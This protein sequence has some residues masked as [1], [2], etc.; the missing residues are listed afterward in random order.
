MNEQPWRFIVGVKNQGDTYDKIYDTLM[1]GNKS[2]AKHAPVLILAIAVNFYERNG[3]PNKH[4]EYD[5]GQA[6]AH[7]TFQASALDLYVHQM[8][9]FSQQK[10]RE[11]FDIPEG[12]SPMTVA[13]VGHLGNIDDLPEEIKIRE[14][15]KRRRKDLDELVFDESFGESSKI[16]NH[17][18]ISTI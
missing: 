7:L 15:S 12:Y 1:D 3:Q 5:L 9:G 6:L 13:A 18:T 10:A 8:G 4:A 16:V 2:W 17:E 11:K 14:K